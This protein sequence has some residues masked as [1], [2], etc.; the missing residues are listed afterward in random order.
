MLQIVFFS[1]CS[2]VNVTNLDLKSKLFQD[3]RPVM[4][5][6][7]FV[8]HVVKELVELESGRSK[9]GSLSVEELCELAITCKK[10]YE[11]EYGRLDG[12]PRWKGKHKVAGDEEDNGNDSDQ[13]IEMTEEEIE[14]ACRQLNS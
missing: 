2:K 11:S 4:E 10:V 3:M 5:Q 8:P 12:S 13:T 9:K 14:I 1:Q 6:W 7:M